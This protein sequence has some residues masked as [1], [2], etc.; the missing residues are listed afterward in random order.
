M[1][2]SLA[3]PQKLTMISRKVFEKKEAPGI[4]L[5]WRFCHLRSKRIFDVVA[6][7]LFWGLCGGAEGQDANGF[8][9]ALFMDTHL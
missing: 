6:L 3:P 1:V 5:L 7:C 9:Q 8:P 2:G 4:E